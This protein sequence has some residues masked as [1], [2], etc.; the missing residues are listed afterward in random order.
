MA[1]LDTRHS[2]FDTRIVL[3]PYQDEA[4]EAVL[5]A[6]GKGRKRALLVLPTGAGKTIVFSKLAQLAGSRGR[7]TLILAHREELLAQA[8][9]KVHLVWPGA[10]IGL[11][12][13]NSH[14]E[15]RDVTV[16]S[17]QSLHPQRLARLS[18]NYRLVVTDEAHHS[19]AATYRRIYEHFAN[20]LHLGVTATPKRT[21]GR[22]LKFFDEVV[23]T[24]GIPDLVK[25]D[26]LVPISPRR[27]R[28][29]MNLDKIGKSGGDFKASEL[30]KLF[31]DHRQHLPVIEAWFREKK[32]F[33]VQKGL[34]FCVDVAHS[35]ALALA[36]QSIGVKAAWV[37]GEMHRLERAQVLQAFS[38]GEIELI[39][40]CNVLTE[41]FD[42]PSIDCMLM[43]RPTLSQGL[44]IQMVG[45]GLRKFPGKKACRV[46]DFVGATRHKLAQA[47]SFLE[48]SCFAEDSIRSRIRL[49]WERLE[50]GYSLRFHDGMGR[51]Y[52]FRLESL[53]EESGMHRAVMI[54]GK[55][56][57]IITEAPLEWCQGQAE[58]LIRNMMPRK[59]LWAHSKCQMSNV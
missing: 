57:K 28:L 39:T 51:L 29:D 27:I 11:I 20:S 10:R 13:G 49:N 2:T 4:A 18:K 17:V 26:Y 25:E 48:D 22:G 59:T 6:Y 14:R 54:H 30:A 58:E 15:G 42:E 21:D 50:N 7:R 8:I 46:L 31:S 53:D 44:Y 33:G 45:R 52:D 37:A 9:D 38:R 35:K 1:T 43:V 32:Y 19:P 34:A 36:F 24:L 5:R 16:A 47:G 12:R 3:R 55:T 23:Y 40:N 56:R 41:G